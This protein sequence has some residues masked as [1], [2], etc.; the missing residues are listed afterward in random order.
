MAVGF[1]GD[2]ARRVAAATTWVEGVRRNDP[3]GPR[4]PSKHS[5]LGRWIKITSAHTEGKY[6]WVAVKWNATHAYEEDADAGSGDKDAENGYAVEAIYKSEHVILNSIVW[7]Y[8]AM[9]QDYYLFDYHPSAQQGTT[10]LTDVLQ[11]GTDTVTLATGET[12][13]ATNSL[14]CTISASSSVMLIYKAGSWVMI[15]AASTVR[16]VTQLQV[17]GLNLEYKYRDVCVVP[18]GPE[19]GWTIWHT[20]SDC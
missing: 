10:G 1:T 9:G 2:G 12:V 7:A 8:P 18:S 13:T 19:S 20:G 6:S 16:V 15:P 11:G 17:N 14:Y 4:R 5:P 3:A